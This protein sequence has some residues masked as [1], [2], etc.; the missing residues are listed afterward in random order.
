MVCSAILADAQ[1]LAVK[2]AT[3]GPP[4]RGLT[5]DYRRAASFT[6]RTFAPSIHGQR[7]AHSQ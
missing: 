5:D 2:S 7:L 6:G 1:G 3:I 4:A